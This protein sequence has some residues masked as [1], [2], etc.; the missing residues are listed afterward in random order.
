MTENG[1]DAV[2]AVGPP[3]V[4]VIIQAEIA[5]AR[6]NYSPISRR[7]I[8]LALHDQKQIPYREAFDMVDVYCDEHESAVPG[9][10]SSEFGIFYLKVIAVLNVFVGLVLAYFGVRAFQNPRG[11]MPSWAWFTI[12]TLFIGFATLCWVKSI[13]REL[14]GR[15]S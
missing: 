8:A 5:K 15:S 7:M 11:T 12:T 4:E 1:L 2:T 14:G 6:A 3:T 9:Y 13:E 10:I